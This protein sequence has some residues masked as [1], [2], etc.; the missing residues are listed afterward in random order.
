MQV[1]G[2]TFGFRP[3]FAFAGCWLYAGE[4][5]LVHLVQT[6]DDKAPS[7][8]ATINHFALRVADI[9]EAALTLAARGAPFE[10]GDTPGG[11][12]RH[13]RLAC[14]RPA[15]SVNIGDGRNRATTARSGSIWTMFDVAFSAARTIRVSR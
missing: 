11:E 6:E 1:L 3:D 2:L 4:K 10:R 15:S 12:A 5:D 14:R 8:V 7:R 9:G 13:W